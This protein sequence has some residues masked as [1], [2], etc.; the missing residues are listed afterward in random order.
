MLVPTNTKFMQMRIWLEG[1]D[2]RTLE[3]IARKLNS[4]KIKPP[5]EFSTVMQEVKKDV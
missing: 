4:W 2:K 5:R 1:P 3:R